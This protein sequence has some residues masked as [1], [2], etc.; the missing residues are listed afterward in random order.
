VLITGP[1]SETVTD[2]KGAIAYALRSSGVRFVGS[3]PPG[4][5]TRYDP[6]KHPHDQVMEVV[7]QPADAPAGGGVIA[8]AVFDDFP[9]D[10]PPRERAR[11]AVVVTLTPGAGA[12]GGQP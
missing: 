4:I 2:L 1:H 6:A 5:G 7:E 10:A 3:A 9:S 11:R 12:S 8:R